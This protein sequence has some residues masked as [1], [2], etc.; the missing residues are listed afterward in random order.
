MGNN[1]KE[2][3]KKEHFVPRCYLERWKS[4]KGQVWVYDKKLKRSRLN[5]VYDVACER[6]FYDIDYK[7]LSAQKIKLLKELG[8]EVSQDEQ[9][10][11]HFSLGMWREYSQTY[12]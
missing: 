6:Y 8:I 2:K 12:Y 11:E 1:K 7:E 3:T 5:N 9:F 4:D 10:L